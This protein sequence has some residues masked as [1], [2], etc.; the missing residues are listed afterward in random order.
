M[1]QSN[2]TG[3]KLKERWITESEGLYLALASSASINYSVL[4]ILFYNMRHVQHHA[5]QLNL[6]L[7]QTINKAHDYVS[8]AAD[9][10]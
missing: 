8:M 10:L 3:E 5:A 7:R 9:D 1:P 4:E 6:I 2:F